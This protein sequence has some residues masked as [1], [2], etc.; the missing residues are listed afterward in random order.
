MFPGGEYS[1]VLAD[2]QKRR[3]SSYVVM[4]VVYRGTSHTRKRTHRGLR[5]ENMFKS[6]PFP[7]ALS[8]GILP[9]T[10]RTAVG[11]RNGMQPIT[12]AWTTPSQC[13]PFL[14]KGVCGADPGCHDP[15]DMEEE[16]ALINLMVKP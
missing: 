1:L 11:V 9:M 4:L 5:W 7:V 6:K 2:R 13:K 12:I 3:G 16:N 8:V 14:R 15:R 10:L